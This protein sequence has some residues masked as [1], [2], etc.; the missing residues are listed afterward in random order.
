MAK[1]QSQMLKFHAVIKLKR[2]EQNAVLREK[3][4]IILAILKDGLTK[5]FEE[6]GLTPPQYEIFNQ[7]SYDLGTGNQPT[8]GDF[9]IDVGIRIKI[10]KD[11]YLDPVEVK[12]WIYEALKDHTQRV[13]MRRPCVTV[14]YQQ[15][16]EPIYHVD[17]AIYSDGSE[18]ADGKTYL[19]KGKLNSAAEHRIWEE[20]DPQGLSDSI[21]S[22]FQDRED[23]KQFRRAI[24]YLK[25]WKDVVF[26]SSGNAAPRG[27]ALTIAAY[28]WFV[29]CKT[30]DSFANTTEYDDLEAARILVAAMLNQFQLISCEG[31][32]VNRLQVFL[33]TAPYS[34][35]FEKMTNS[36]M[37][38]F[39]EK[40]ESLLEA[41]QEAQRLV[42]LTDACEVLVQHFGDDFPVPDKT[43][44][45]Q[46]HPRSI[47]SAS[48]SA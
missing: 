47:T 22:R 38:K 12:T 3:R 2:F 6:K 43:T 33:P 9:D 37:A 17:F 8:E 5:M 40:L 23:D 21:K 26:S 14:F 39:K 45:A 27:I 46:T 18:N 48:A 7:G 1:I 11:D 19:A 30:F 42:D 32:L 20:A 34:D 28:N 4:D 35:L 13:E 29:A 25:R 31:E 24:R 10:S 41:V 15:D 44:T 16:G 36:Q